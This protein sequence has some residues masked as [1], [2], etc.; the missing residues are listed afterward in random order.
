[1]SAEGGTKAIIVALF[2]NVGIA[3]TK[4]VAWV[5]SGS[6]SLLAEAVHSLADS[7]NQLLLLI[8]GRKAKRKA[9]VEHPFGYGRERYVYAFL[10]AIILFTVGGMFSVYEGVQKISNP[11]PLENVWLPLTV[12]AVAM[13]LEGS[14]L[15]TA[16]IE[17]NKARG[18]DSWWQFI[19][20]SKA[21]ELPVILLEDTAALLGLSFA[22]V[23]VGLAVITGNPLWDGVGT[24]MIGVLLVAVAVILAIET[25][26]LLIGEGASLVD[27]QRIVVA[28]TNGPEVE[29]L[30]HMRTLY[31]GPEELL[32]AAKVAFAADLSLQQ[33]AAH[34]NTVEGRI[35]EAVPI[36]RM[37]YLEP[38][39]Y[40]R[41]QVHP[42]AS[43]ERREI[44]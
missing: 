33:V 39:V 21:P 14:A 30:I 32:I 35:R 31:L 2:A 19:R 28:I 38:D 25:K 6:S 36:A 18:G 8:G 4:F 13:V 5:F 42:D 10:V 3:A 43:S 16:V 22:F 1:M 9:D 44:R 34:I 27:Q 20:H 15:R 26:S 17:S 11:H 23:G 7:G 41:E 12:L 37:I 40:R 29:R 24:L